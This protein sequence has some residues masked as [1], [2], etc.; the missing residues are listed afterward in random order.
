MASSRQ[1]LQI[2]PFLIRSL[3][4]L[5]EVFFV[6]CFQHAVHALLNSWFSRSKADTTWL[7]TSAASIALGELKET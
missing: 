6:V 1:F 2:L 5:I 3:V 7:T 4:Q